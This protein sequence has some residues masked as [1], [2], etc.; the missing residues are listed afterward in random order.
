MKEDAVACFE[1]IFHLTL[2][3]ANEIHEQC[4][5]AYLGAWQKS[6]GSMLRN[7]TPSTYHVTIGL[8]SSYWVLKS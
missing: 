3:V 6:E 8:E 5:P 4:L 7:T 1:V 2:I